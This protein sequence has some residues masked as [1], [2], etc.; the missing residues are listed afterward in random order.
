MAM[1]N[2]QDELRAAEY[3]DPEGLEL[4]TQSDNT[5]DDSLGH[6]RPSSGARLG[7]AAGIWRKAG[8]VTAGLALC[9]TLAALT[10]HHTGAYRSVHVVVEHTVGLQEI[11]TDLAAVKASN[12]DWDP[13]YWDQLVSGKQG[14]NTQAAANQKTCCADEEEFAGLCYKKCELLTGNE[15]PIRTTAFT[16]CKAQPCHPFNSRK[17]MGFCSGFS[18]GACGSDKD[19]CPKPPT[20]C[21][22]DEEV[23]AGVCYTKCSSLTNNEYTHRLTNMACCK[24]SMSYKCLFNGNLKVSST[25]N[26]GSGVTEMQEAVGISTSLPAQMQQAMQASTV[27]QLPPT[28]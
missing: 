13:E 16:C 24:I 23:T 3:N 15:Y 4:L 6:A 21:S 5:D 2:L 26:V 12:P 8:L 20:A 17:D 10:V 14:E 9:G 25:F 19:T 28:R 11:A 7:A 27:G 22:P 18:V 1:S